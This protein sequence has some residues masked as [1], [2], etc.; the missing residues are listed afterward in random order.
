MLAMAVAAIIPMQ[1]IIM[2]L[3]FMMAVIPILVIGLLF[4]TP[5]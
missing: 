4:I 1:S 3:K 2:L 5:C